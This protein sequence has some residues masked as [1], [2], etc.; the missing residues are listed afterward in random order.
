MAVD[1]KLLELARSNPTG[2]RYE[3]ACKLAEQFQWIRREGKGSHIVFQHP[4]G[5]RIRDRYPQ[6]L[7]LQKGRDGKAKAYQ[8]QQMLRMAEAMGILSELKEEL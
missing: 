3:D 8:I 4:N 5:I 7:N 2:M 1:K 6:P